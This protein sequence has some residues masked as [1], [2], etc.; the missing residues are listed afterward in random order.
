MRIGFDAKRAYHNNTGLGNYS[1]DLIKGMANKYRDD[2]YLLFTPRV[3]TNPRI[4]FTGYFPNITPVIPEGFLDRQFKSYWRSVN[5]EKDLVKHRIDLYHGLSQ[6][7]PRRKGGRLKYVVTI[8]DLIFLRYPETYKAV[9]RSIYDKKF[10]YA[11][12]NSDLVIAISEQTKSDLVEFYKIDPNRIRV[13]YQSCHDQFKSM[14]PKT[15][16]QAILEKY[17]LP[18]T[19]ILYVGTIEKRKNLSTLIRAANEIDIPVVAVGKK[20][21]YYQEVQA[22]VS[23]N[24]MGDR[25]F[26]LENIPFPEL[27]AIYQSATAFCYPS[28]FE[29]FG[30]PIIEALY[31]KVPVITS[32]GGVFPETGGPDTIYIDPLNPDELKSAIESVLHSDQSE[33]IQKGYDFV[34]QFSTD[35]FVEGTRSVYNELL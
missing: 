18:S 8:H 27:P 12:E 26:F 19:F 1:R 7:I 28:V 31:S 34:Q 22:V 15:E 4:A 24:N 30:I 23:A 14:V 17:N 5:M 6:E 33:R 2:E 20:T 13:V 29:G 21:D 16:R 9:D 35:N 32:Q 25:V 10:R 3:S 11:S